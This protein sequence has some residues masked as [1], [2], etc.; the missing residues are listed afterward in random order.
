MAMAMAERRATVV[1]AL[2]TSLDPHTVLRKSEAAHR[3][4]PVSAR[5]GG[6]ATPRNHEELA[7]SGPEREQA[8]HQTRPGQGTVP[9]GAWA[10]V[11]AMR[12]SWQSTVARLAQRDPVRRQAR[13]RPSLHAGA[14]CRERT[15]RLVSTS[16]RRP[17]P[18]Y[19]PRP[20]TPGPCRV[21]SL[22]EPDICGPQDG[23]GGP[24]PPLRRR[25]T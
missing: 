7:P 4:V 20:S 10:F 13:L 15:P 21:F 9:L 14:R 19:A 6:G 2:E 23:G 8:S 11:D 5:F 1:C 25:P 17:A 24:G 22:S 12:A 18:A 3:Y 16:H